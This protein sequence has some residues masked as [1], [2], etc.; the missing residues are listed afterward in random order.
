MWEC[1]KGFVLY[2]TAMCDFPVDRTVKQSN[3]SSSEATVPY[4]LIHDESTCA[5]FL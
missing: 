4:H 1:Y 3:S 2:V 5:F